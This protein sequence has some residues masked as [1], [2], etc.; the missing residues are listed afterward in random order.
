M[1]RDPKSYRA[2]TG[3]QEETP[4]HP[5]LHLSAPAGPEVFLPL[6]LMFHLSAFVTSSF[7]SSHPSPTDT[8]PS[9]L[10]KAQLHHS[11]HQ[12][13]RDHLSE[14]KMF[15]AGEGENLTGEAAGK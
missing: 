9:W 5:Q 4:L 6:K 1:H 13:Q 10:G 12:T 7:L 2:N 3:K 14:V 11:P 15:L 8:A